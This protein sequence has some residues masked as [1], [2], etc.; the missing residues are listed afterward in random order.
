M[1]KAI[2]F[3]GLLA[4]VGALVSQYDNT[5]LL[6]ILV[7]AI[8]GTTYSIPPEVMFSTNL[9]LLLFLLY[10]VIPFRRIYKR[11]TV[12]MRSTLRR[13]RPLQEPQYSEL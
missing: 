4:V 9:C 1:P 10:L 11:L 3:C 13:K 12:L 5:I 2:I 6:F 8:P 7:G